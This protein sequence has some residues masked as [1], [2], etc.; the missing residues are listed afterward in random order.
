M[1]VAGQDS[2]WGS[3]CI[4]EPSGELILKLVNPSGRVSQKVIAVSDARLEGRGSMTILTGKGPAEV[5][6]ME[7]PMEV[8]PVTRQLP[9]KGRKM[10]LTLPAYSLVVVRVKVN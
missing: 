7:E 9:L 4:D 2:C 3:A 5:N 1:P 10:Y 6:S 8:A